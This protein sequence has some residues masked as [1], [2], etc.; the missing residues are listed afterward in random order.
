MR[1]AA[2]VDGATVFCFRVMRRANPNLQITTELSQGAN[3]TFLSET[4]SSSNSAG[5]RGNFR[6]SELYAAGA[7]Y[8]PSMLDALICQSFYSPNLVHILR[9]LLSGGTVA[10]I[11][12]E[13][14]GRPASPSSPLA[15]H[16]PPQRPAA[17]GGGVLAPVHPGGMMQVPVPPEYVGRAFGDLFRYMIRYRGCVVLGL[18][19]GPGAG[20][21]CTPLAG[22]ILRVTLCSA[23]RALDAL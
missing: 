21:V 4:V 22:L 1:G 3:V 16:R 5:L 23:L 9:L 17:D 6:L 8:S 19:R 20:L 10:P 13:E 14:D 11:H 2:A 15:Q 12:F 18:Y 7:M